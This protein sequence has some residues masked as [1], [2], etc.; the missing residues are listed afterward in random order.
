MYW[1]SSFPAFQMAEH[2]RNAGQSGYWC[3]DTALIFWPWVQS[4]RGPEFQ[5][6]TSKC[7]IKIPNSFP[8]SFF[9]DGALAHIGRLFL[10]ILLLV[11]FINSTEAFLSLLFS[12]ISQTSGFT[13]HTHLYIHTYIHICM[14]VYTYTDLHIYVLIYYYYF[15]KPCAVEIPHLLVACLNSAWEWIFL[16]CFP[17]MLIGDIS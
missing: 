1:C 16:D 14:S 12:S 3:R 5:P 17:L 13:T 7:E 8:L 11:N 4:P 15:N 9:F 6:I 2:L 10:L